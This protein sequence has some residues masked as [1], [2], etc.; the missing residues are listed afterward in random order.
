MPP[1]ERLLLVEESLQR[2]EVD[3]PEAAEL[4]MLKIF[5]GL[6]NKEIGQT[7]GISEATV[8][9]RWNFAKVCLFQIICELQGMDVPSGA[10]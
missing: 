8:A 3:D 1:D 9:R 6:T 10:A 7:Q 4:V 2:L 5:A